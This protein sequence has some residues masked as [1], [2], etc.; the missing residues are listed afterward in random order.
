M[1]NSASL[2][3]P[4]GGSITEVLKP[5]RSI[6]CLERS[7]LSVRL[8]I[9][10]MRRRLRYFNRSLDQINEC[11]DYRFVSASFDPARILRMPKIE[12]AYVDGHIYKGVSVFG[13]DLGTGETYEWDNL[14]DAQDRYQY[15]RP[16][17]L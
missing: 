14:I 3:Q 5:T 8:E 2:K 11:E 7:C 9:S 4:T 13:V 12:E 17:G 1:V 6:F 15:L 16:A 10:F